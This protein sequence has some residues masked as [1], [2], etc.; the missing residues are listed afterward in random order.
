MESEAIKNDRLP[1]PSRMPGVTSETKK[2]GGKLAA[3]LSR[4]CCFFFVFLGFFWFFWRFLASACQHRSRA[5]IHLRACV[6]AT[7]SGR[8]AGVRSVVLVTH[9][10]G[11]VG[12]RTVNVAQQR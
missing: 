1:F 4:V 11:D 6:R 9:T 3:A 12:V 5:H 8:S 2:E 7:H 10:G